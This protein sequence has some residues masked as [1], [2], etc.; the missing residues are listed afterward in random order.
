MSLKVHF[1]DASR[2][3]NDVGS[4]GVK[5]D[6]DAARNGLQQSQTFIVSDLTGSIEAAMIQKLGTI[7]S[8]WVKCG[9]AISLS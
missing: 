6:I 1:P 2:R 5:A 3:A 4:S 8:R 9:G 7:C